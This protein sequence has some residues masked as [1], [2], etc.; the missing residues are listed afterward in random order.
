M[1]LG[2]RASVGCASFRAPAPSRAL[3]IVRFQ[4]R[5]AVIIGA[6]MTWPEIAVRCDQHPRSGGFPTAD[7]T[8]AADPSIFVGLIFRNVQNTSL[9]ASADG[10]A[11]GGLSGGLRGGGWGGV[12]VGV[13]GAGGGGW[14]GGGR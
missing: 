5:K 7:Q 9:A 2:G 3:V 11:G 1:G 10:K 12:G 4:R 13:V 8:N 14:G 6:E